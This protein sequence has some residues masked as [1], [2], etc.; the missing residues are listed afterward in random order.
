[1]GSDKTAGDFIQ[2]LTPSPQSFERKISKAFSCGINVI[3][4]VYNA[5]FTRILFYAIDCL[6]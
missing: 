3:P 5:I 6:N 4:S 2:H 1:M